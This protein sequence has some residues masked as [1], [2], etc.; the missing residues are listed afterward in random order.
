MHY[1]DLNSRLERIYISINTKL[2]DGTAE[3]L[4]F[5]RETGSFSSNPNQVLEKI[6][7]IVSNLSN[8]K[9]H[10]KKAA[11]SKGV[12]KN[13]IEK[14]IENYLPLKLII[15]INNAEK[16]GYPVTSKRSNLDPK[17]VNVS[18]GLKVVGD[19]A[20]SISI[21][22]DGRI[23][24]SGNV[25][26]ILDADIVDFHNNKICKFSELRIKSI[27]AWEKIILKFSLT[28]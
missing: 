12:D 22:P 1:N 15:D 11:T 8:L 27:D 3:Y 2:E 13:L 21:H 24:Q 9:D 20:T 28:A 23:E 18:S 6:L 25:E 17:I 7:S 14:E 5:N 16:H 19:E 26:T 10:L 4:R